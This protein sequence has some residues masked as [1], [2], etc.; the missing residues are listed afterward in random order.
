MGEHITMK[1]SKRTKLLIALL[2]IALFSIFVVSRIVTTQDFNSA[3]IKSLD[4][5]KVTVLKLAATAAASSTALSLIPG[6]VAT[7]IANQIA[8]L[9]TYFI[10]IL[11]AILLEKILIAVVGYLTFTFIVPFSCALGILYLYSKKEVLRT[12]AIKLAIF[13]IVLFAAIPTSIKVSD[14]I[15]ESYQES[16]ELTVETANQNKEYI[17][18]KKKDIST[19]DQNWVEKIGNYLSDVTSKIGNDI[20]SMV[21]KGEDTLTAFLDAIAVMI[22]T[23]C[24][25]PI[26]VILIFAWIIKILFGF[27]SNGSL[28][29]LREK[30]NKEKDD[31][32]IKK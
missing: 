19:E 15:Y 9:T 21:Q 12:L 8:K 31:L 14:L 27:D 24:V 3:T 29:N 23:S 5:K 17:E 2:F 4:D 18:E 13:G 22:I 30:L 28:T 11:G 6:D 1:F 10:V 32:D 25:I 20:S 7:P 26:V 16:I